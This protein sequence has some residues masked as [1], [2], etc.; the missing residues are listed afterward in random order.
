[1]QGPDELDSGA[2]ALEATGRRLWLC[3]A[4]A[5]PILQP[6][7]Y[8]PLPCSPRSGHSGWHACGGVA[9]PGGVAA[10]S[11]P[12]T[13]A[14]PAAAARDQR[15]AASATCLLRAGGE[16]CSALGR[17]GAGC[18]VV[19]LHW[20]R[21]KPRCWQRACVECTIASAQEGAAQAELLP[22]H[23]QPSASAGSCFK[24]L[25]PHSKAIKQ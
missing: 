21:R 9:G 4:L 18:A 22:L 15:P 12:P 25:H 17:S 23:C 13:A 6:P 14:D 24:S 16:L 20:R 10:S 11:A 3:L 19:G 1:M 7:P 5:L 2:K 8:L